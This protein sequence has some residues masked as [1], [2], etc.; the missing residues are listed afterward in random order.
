MTKLHQ[1]DKAPDFNLPSST[2]KNISLKDL[3]GKN[4]VLYFYPKDDTPGCTLE[5]CGFRDMKKVFEK[6]NAVVLGVSPDNPKSHEKFIQKFN[7]PF[8]LLSD[9]T[10]KMCE[11]YGVLAKKSMFG[12]SYMG[13]VRTTFVI[14]RQGKIAKIF[15]GVNPKGHQ[16]EVLEFLQQLP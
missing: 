4:I 15:E 6:Q 8:T 7:L 13:I 2:G 3:R 12:K 10:K 9:E 16:D 11:D 14:D 1:N 5:A